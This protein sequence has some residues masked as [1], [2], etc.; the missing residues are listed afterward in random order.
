MHGHQLPTP[1][2]QRAN[3]NH[4]RV[5]V[6]VGRRAAITRAGGSRR[7]SFAPVLITSQFSRESPYLV[8]DLCLIAGVLIGR[9]HGLALWALVPTLRFVTRLQSVHVLPREYRDCTQNP[10]CE[11]TPAPQPF[12]PTRSS[13]ELGR[14]RHG[15]LTG[16][17]G[18]HR[19]S[20]PPLLF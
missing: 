5:E 20:P 10:D 12:S 4:L 9:E 8:V 15:K 14:E 1:V 6:G 11:A 2:R 13:S 7:P 3:D 17:C 19:F 18:D 16:C